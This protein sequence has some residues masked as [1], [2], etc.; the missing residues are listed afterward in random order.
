MSVGKIII[1]YVFDRLGLN[2]FEC[3][4]VDYDMRLKGI[5]EKW[6]FKVDGRL[7]DES[8]LNGTHYDCIIM[9]LTQKDYQVTKDA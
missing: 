8:F 9:S 4:F 3:A 2:K 7:R 6:G 1:P 5:L